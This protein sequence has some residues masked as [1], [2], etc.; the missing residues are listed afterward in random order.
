LLDR[1][2]SLLADIYDL[3]MSYDVYD[4][5]V[6]DKA[7]ADSLDA[8][9]R[10]VDE[11]LLIVEHGDH[12]DVSLYLES[13]LVDRLTEHDP[14]RRLDTH[15]FADFLTVFEGVSHFAYY[16][17]NAALDKPVRLLEMELQAEV[18]K[19]IATHLLLRRQGARAPSRLHR[20]L[21]DEPRYD[22]RLSAAELTRYRYANHYAGKYCLKLEPG[23]AD[24]LR[25]G[26]RLLAELREFYRLS[27]P[28]KIRHIESR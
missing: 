19:F 5:L 12:A 26:R 4:F 25:R 8:D 27:Q 3:E 28:S 7:V 10:V 24:G 18:D 22:H 6:T 16:A 20:W 15:N 2:Q 23:I 13:S 9:G 11:K 14:S 21:F 1:L 17:W